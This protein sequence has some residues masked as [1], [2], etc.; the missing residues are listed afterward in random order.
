VRSSKEPQVAVFHI[1]RRIDRIR[2]DPGVDPGT[3]FQLSEV[4]L[5]TRRE[6]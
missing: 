6:H 5:L 4:A 1:G 3:V 2:L